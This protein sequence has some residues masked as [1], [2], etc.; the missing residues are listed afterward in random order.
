[1]PWGHAGLV[2]AAA[3]VAAGPA[4]A[5]E[6]LD[7]KLQ[8]HGY[9]EIQT[10]VLA[11]D[12]SPNDGYHLAQWYNILNLELEWDVAPRA[13]DPSTSCRPSC[14]PRSA[15]TASGR[16][17]ATSSAA[18]ATRTATA[19]TPSA[20]RG[21]SNARKDGLV[22]V[23]DPDEFADKRNLIQLPVGER[24]SMYGAPAG[25]GQEAPNQRGVGTLWNL[26]GLSD[27][28]FAGAG[29]D[30]IWG[31]DDDPAD[32]RPSASSTTAS[33][34]SGFPATSAATASTSRG[35]GAPRTRSRSRER[36]A[37]ARIPSTRKS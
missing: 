20:C 16:G 6:A 7:G 12:Y 11:R 31:T 37:T 27:Q 34:S 32:T 4:R 5:F 21:A 24:L 9:F 26:P 1:M 2:V 33:P 10:R 18:S 36:C 30:K 13:G 17:A 3:L 28:F 22:G 8:L 19:T 29:Y 15:T 35:P 23:I 25:L 14:A